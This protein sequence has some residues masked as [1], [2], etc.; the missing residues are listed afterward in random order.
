MAMSL[1]ETKDRAGLITDLGW[2]VFPLHSTTKATVLDG[3]GLLVTEHEPADV[4]AP[5]A[6]AHVEYNAD[7]WNLAERKGGFY[8]G[9]DSPGFAS[10]LIDAA[11]HLTGAIPR[12]GIT[13]DLL[14]IDVDHPEHVP[15]D[16]RKHLEKLPGT[17]GGK[18]RI[19]ALGTGQTWRSGG[20]NSEAGDQIG[21]CKHLRKSYSVAYDDFASLQRLHTAD[22]PAAG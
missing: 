11:Y 17:H 8:W 7:G 5:W 4:L 6:L 3:P 2:Y 13:S 21:D 12:L 1:A 10:E 9:T 20:F 14:L 22:G 19:A 16:M 15:E 18:H